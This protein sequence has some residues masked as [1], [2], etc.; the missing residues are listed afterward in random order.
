MSIRR[1]NKPVESDCET[2][3]VAELDPWDGLMYWLGE[4][5]FLHNP[6]SR[7][8]VFD[9][10]GLVTRAMMGDYSIGRETWYSK[11]RSRYVRSGD[12]LELYRALRHISYS[13]GEWGE[14]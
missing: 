11:H 2:C 4:V 9:G 12:V 7:T 5:M 1:R 10:F 8:S 14:S 6:Y 3:R 13:N